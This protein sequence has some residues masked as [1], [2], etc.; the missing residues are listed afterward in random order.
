MGRVGHGHVRREGTDLCGSV[1][2]PRGYS[3]IWSEAELE[4]WELVVLSRRSRMKGCGI[5][6]DG[7][8]RE[9]QDRYL[10]KD[11]ERGGRERELY[12]QAPLGLRCALCRGGLGGSVGGGRSTPRALPASSR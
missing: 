4:F 12:A 6:A 10:A 8:C 5:V 11:M 2:D 3:V 1:Y 7:C 9:P